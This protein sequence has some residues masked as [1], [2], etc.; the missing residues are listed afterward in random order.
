MARWILTL[1]L[2]RQALYNRLV[3]L[4][5][6]ERKFSPVQTNRLKV[7]DRSADLQSLLSR[8]KLNYIPVSF[9]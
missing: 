3:P 9:V 1:I 8:C 7:S 5:G 2:C 4:I 6:G